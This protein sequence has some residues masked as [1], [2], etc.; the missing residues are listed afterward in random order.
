[1]PKLNNNLK[2]LHCFINKLTELPKIHNNLREIDCRYNE[3]PEFIFSIFIL[4]SKNIKTINVYYCKF[5]IMCLK[6]K[7]HF[8]RWL[9]E[10]VRRPKIEREF[11]PDRLIEILNSMKDEENEDEFMDVLEKW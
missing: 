4:D 2:I 6:Y 1:L 5:R 11:H 3:L 10:R 7:E 8:R 9:W